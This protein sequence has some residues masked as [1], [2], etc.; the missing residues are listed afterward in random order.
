M[1]EFV[2]LVIHFGKELEHV[3]KVF[4]ILPFIFPFQSLGGHL[5]EV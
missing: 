3:V 4:A 2:V 1:N 5:R